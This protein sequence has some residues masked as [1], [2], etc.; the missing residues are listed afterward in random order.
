MC[1]IDITAWALIH[2]CIYDARDY[3]EFLA[4]QII[5]T[6]F[7]IPWIFDKLHLS[8]SEV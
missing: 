6:E 5:F 7:L 4:F 8:E 2:L 1:S 3:L